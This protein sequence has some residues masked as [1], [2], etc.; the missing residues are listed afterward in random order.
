MLAQWL[1]PNGLQWV[2]LPMLAALCTACGWAFCPLSLRALASN[3]LEC[4]I[5]YAMVGAVALSWVGTILAVAGVFRP[6]ALL[7][8]MLAAWWAIRSLRSRN[9]REENPSPQ[10]QAPRWVAWM[11]GAFLIAAG[12]AYARPAESFVIPYDAGVYTLGGIVLARDGTLNAHE[13]FFYSFSEEASF[14]SYWHYVPKGDPFRERY[15]E[16]ARQ[17]YEVQWG[18]PPRFL[19][20]VGGPFYTWGK[21]RA[22][23]E[24]GFPPLTKVW[25]AF[26]VWLFGQ[27]YGPWA[28]PFFGVLGLAALYLLVR[29][30]A[31]WGTAL[32]TVALLAF[33]LPQ[34]WFARFPT[35]DIYGQ[36]FWAGGLAF[37]LAARRGNGCQTREGLL[38]SALALGALALLRLEGLPLALFLA[39]CGALAWAFQKKGGEAAFWL[40]GVSAVC[41]L[42]ELLVLIATPVYTLSLSAVRA[43][44]AVAILAGLGALLGWRLLWVRKGIRLIWQNGFSWAIVAIGCGWFVW[45]AYALW[46]LLSQPWSS[47]LPGWLVQYWTRPA[48]ALALA[49]GILLAWEARAGTKRPEV[50]APLA[51]GLLLLALYSRHAQVTPLHPWAMRRLVPLVMPMLALGTSAMVNALASGGASLVK[52]FLPKAQRLP[53]WGAFG[54]GT[55]LLAGLT[56][57][58]GQRAYPILW[59]REREGLYAQLQALDARLSPGSVVL[60][61]SG[62]YADQLAPTMQFLLGHPTFI[63]RHNDALRSDSGVVARFLRSAVDAGYEVFYVATGEAYRPLPQGW[64]LRPEGGEAIRT[65]VLLYPWGRPP[66][67]KDIALETI[68]VDVYRVIAAAQEAPPAAHEV[69]IPIGLGSYPYL[70]EGFYGFEQPDGHFPYRWTDGRALVQVPW[71]QEAHPAALC[72]E[73][74]MSPGRPPQEAPPQVTLEVEGKAAGQTRLEA[75]QE[76]TF[77]FPVENIQ[78]DG[79]GYLALTLISDT[80][81]PAQTLADSQ[82]TRHLGVM[83]YGLTVHFDGACPAGE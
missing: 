72:I 4:L 79:D 25:Q 52:R 34:V 49:G 47:S 55:V 70:R 81:V 10:G 6:W 43:G 15:Q 80:W 21:D 36:A 37:A 33:S 40:A 41:I 68:L 64:A 29:H 7:G 18:F 59:H 65:P 54:L 82:D 30:L 38:W 19:K 3:A 62:P 56:Y 48:L 9:G 60:M 61:G 39:G 51:S 12:W 22:T 13:A 32:G 69:E 83:V 73:V 71:P 44:A 50:F 67:A 23:I 26:C 53:R 8:A 78:D 66:T 35:S 2:I 27:A 17:F 63:L 1:P 46:A 5:L 45:G 75:A 24:I 58:I 16:Y 57:G 76:R 20:F 42:G 31:G 74:A 11:L 77:A 14:P 28:T